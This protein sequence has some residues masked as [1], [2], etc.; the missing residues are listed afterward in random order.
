MTKRSDQQIV[1]VANSLAREFYG[2]M[3]CEV[4]EG[5]RFDRAT[6]P[7]ERM[8]WEMACRA[9]DVIDHTE[10]SEALAAVEDDED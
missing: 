7:Q 10:V 6:H 5:Y 3:G 4:P 1:A 8:C 9:F 2:L